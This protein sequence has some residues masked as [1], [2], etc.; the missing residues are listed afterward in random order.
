M[1]RHYKRWNVNEELKLQREY[2]LLQMTIQE[3]AITHKRTEEA[4]LCKLKKEG[5][6]Q[7]WNEATGYTEYEKYLHDL[8]NPL[9]YYHV[10]EVEYEEVQGN[11]DNNNNQQRLWTIINEIKNMVSALL[12][13]KDDESSSSSHID[14]YCYECEN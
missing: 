3:I 6:I 9:S 5:F 7:E 14:Y 12:Y 8:M 1:S 4:I 2:E 11:N 10:D 13:K